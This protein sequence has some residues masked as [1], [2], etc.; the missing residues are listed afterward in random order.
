V[1]DADPES[2]TP[3]LHE[4]AVPVVALASDRSRA[5]ALLSAGARACVPQD[6]D[7][8]RMAAVLEAVVQGFVVLDPAFAPWG[9]PPGDDEPEL[10]VEDLTHRELEVLQLLAEG[11]PNREIAERLGVSENTVKF[12]TGTIYSKL[13]VHSR[14][15]AVAHAARLGLI[16]L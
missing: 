1:C 12:H 2:E 9:H 7:G 3:A 11:L 8:P 4:V 6:I 13:G 5:R 14:T 10:W 16:T 15:E